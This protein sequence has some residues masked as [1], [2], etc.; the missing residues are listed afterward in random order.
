MY[1]EMYWNRNSCP[2]CYRCCMARRRF[3]I[4]A[5]FVIVGIRP[6][7]LL[8]NLPPLSAVDSPQFQGTTARAW[9]RHV[10]PPPLHRY[11]MCD[12][13]SRKPCG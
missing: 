8:K 4:A 10:V 13:S 1:W 5:V 11:V 9:L 7:T 2:W 12:N 3:R 6:I